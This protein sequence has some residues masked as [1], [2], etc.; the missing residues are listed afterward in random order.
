MFKTIKSNVKARN[1]TKVTPQFTLYLPD[2]NYIFS[3]SMPP[4]QLPETI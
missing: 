1:E 3:A 2:S 4:K